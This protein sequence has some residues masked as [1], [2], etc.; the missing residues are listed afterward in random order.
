MSE[1]YEDNLDVL[2]RM[3]TQGSDLTKPRDIDFFVAFPTSNS[4]ELFAEH[5]RKRGYQVAMKGD[6]PAEGLPWDVT[7]TT[8]MVP[9]A[10][11]ITDFEDTLA[12]IA[13]SLGGSNDGWGTMS[14]AAPTN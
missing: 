7:V 5:F 6:G 10:L 12:D 3:A 4:A 11:G 8:R 13:E 14:P 1:A 2:R 9:T